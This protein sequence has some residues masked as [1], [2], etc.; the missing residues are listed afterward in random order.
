MGPI[1]QRFMALAAA[2][3]DL[4]GLVPMLTQLATG[5]ST[6][7][8]DWQSVRAAYGL[9]LDRARAMQL[10]PPEAAE[11]TSPL[12]ASP[13]IDTTPVPPDLGAMP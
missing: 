1:W 3:T 7:W 4:A 13:V 10:T 12:I 9:S 5:G 6:D 2:D 8:P 11:G